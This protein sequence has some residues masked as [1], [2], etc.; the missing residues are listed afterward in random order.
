MMVA[1]NKNLDEFSVQ[2]TAEGKYFDAMIF[3]MMEEVEMIAAGRS[4]ENIM[5]LQDI[6][7]SHE[8]GPSQVSVTQSTNQLNHR[9]TAF[10]VIVN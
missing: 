1:Y 9:P 5:Y 2:T 6:Y 8:A 3:D 10:I 4:D 7:S